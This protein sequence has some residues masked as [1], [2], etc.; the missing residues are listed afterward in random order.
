MKDFTNVAMQ[1]GVQ[2]II[3]VCVEVAS[4]A[5]CRRGAADNGVELRTLAACEDAVEVRA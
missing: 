2:R 5:R 4:D 1:E 3:A